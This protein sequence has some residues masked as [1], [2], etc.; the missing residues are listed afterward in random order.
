[1]TRV[2]GLGLD[3]IHFIHGQTEPWTIKQ[4]PRMGTIPRDPGLVPYCPWPY[5]SMVVHSTGDV[6]AC[7]KFRMDEIYRKSV[8]FRAMGAVARDSISEIFKNP[9]Y[10]TAR[11]LSNNPLKTG[12]KDGHF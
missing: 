1:M 6:T 12:R 2:A 5:F 3:E 4:A 8:P 9:A 10:V 7:C 11:E